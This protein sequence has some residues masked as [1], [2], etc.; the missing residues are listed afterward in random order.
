M[1]GLLQQSYNIKKSE[2]NSSDLMNTW[3]LVRINMTR[4]QRNNNTHDLYNNLILFQKFP[5]W[6]RPFVNCCCCGQKLFCCAFQSSVF[7]ICVFI[8]VE[9]VFKKGLDVRLLFVSDDDDRLSPVDGFDEICL[10]SIFNVLTFSVKLDKSSSDTN[11]ETVSSPSLYVWC[12]SPSISWLYN[13]HHV[14][15]SP[16][17]TATSP[18]SIQK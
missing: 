4:I 16:K 2:K 3:T 10:F 1:D 7:C 14:P 9:F 5:P 13:G 18:G 15:S 12:I 8:F 6:K 11:D 17:Q